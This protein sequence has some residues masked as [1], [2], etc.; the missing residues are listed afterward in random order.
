MACPACGCKVHYQFNSEEDF[1]GDDERLERC[2][3]CRAVFDIED[4]ADEDDEHSEADCDYLR[5]VTNKDC[6]QHS[7]AGVQAFDAVGVEALMNLVDKYRHQVMSGPRT[8]ELMTQTGETWDAIRALAQRLSVSGVTATEM[9]RYEEG[10][11]AMA[12]AL[13]R[14]LD[15]GACL[16]SD[17]PE[18]AEVARLRV[19][20]KDKARAYRDALEE[21]L[22]IE[23]MSPEGGHEAVAEIH[24]VARAALG[25]PLLHPT[26]E[27]TDV[28]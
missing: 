16:A 14:I 6:E 17:P 22:S 5:G 1:V 21:I 12:Q 25:V 28:R 7:T 18:L 26:Q 13:R 11:D 27:N 8:A 15:G 19:Q 9:A 20:A 10:I 24:R 3:A 2:A 4:S 23:P